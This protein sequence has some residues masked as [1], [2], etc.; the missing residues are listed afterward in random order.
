MGGGVG[1]IGRRFGL[2]CDN[3]TGAELVTA[4]GKWLRVSAAENP[5]LFWAVRGGGGNFGVVTSFTFRLHQVTPI[6]YG[7]EITYAFADARQLLRGFADVSAAAPD[8][9]YVDMAMGTAPQGARWLGLTVCYCGP[10]ADAE[11]VVAP[12]RKIGKPLKDELAV[13]PY[14]TL[15]GSADLRGISPLGAYG[16]GGLV[17]GITP[18]LIDTMV[19]F[20]ESSPSDG[21]MMWMQHQGGA[22]S[23]VRPKDTA[24][25]NRGA[26]HNVGVFA[27]W[28]M[29]PGD[30]ERE[31][32]WVRR[33]WAKIEPQ[34]RGQYVNLAASDDRE[35]RVHAA[36]GDNYPRLAALKKRYDPANLFRLNA[37]IKPA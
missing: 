4:D 28:K 20:T 37:N 8:E 32:D 2:T 27:S 3:L 31:I 10:R 21:A 34:T 24:Y 11:R 7:G 33:A 30:T 25:F 22:I 19:E 12:L 23:R 9:L 5:D 29:P 1:R 36:Y 14:V 6:M 16:K 17:Y 13:A 26:S 18:T 15:Q 35:A